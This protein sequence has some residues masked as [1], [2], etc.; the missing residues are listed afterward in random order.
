MEDESDV[1]KDMAVEEENTPSQNTD[2][3]SLDNVIDRVTEA[4][5]NLP[6][7]V[8][9]MAASEDLNSL[10]ASTQKVPSSEPGSEASSE[11][12]SFTK[13][14]SN[15]D[16]PTKFREILE[17]SSTSPLPHQSQ[18]NTLTSRL[19]SIS[20][21]LFNNAVDSDSNASSANH[22]LDSPMASDHSVDDESSDS[23][24]IVVDAED[25]EPTEGGE[26]H[27]VDPFPTRCANGLPHWA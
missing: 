1:C 2:M 21:P 13:L 18:F 6:L 14:D 27:E 5:N 24:H 25:K 17:K 12:R 16:H 15:D 7:R 26:A 8:R 19:N 3:T 10:R 4:I 22:V 9:N 23:L 11:G 20:E